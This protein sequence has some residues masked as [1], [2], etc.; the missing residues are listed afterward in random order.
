MLG[1]PQDVDRYLVGAN[2]RLAATPAAVRATTIVRSYGERT[3]IGYWA[4]L[5]GVT[6]YT[7]GLFNPTSWEAGYNATQLDHNKMGF[8][9]WRAIIPRST[10][11]T[12]MDVSKCYAYAFVFWRTTNYE[13]HEHLF[14]YF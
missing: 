9:Q 13:L 2:K 12:I 14:L 4:E 10:Y 11:I 7:Q 5:L 8:G 3:S 6:G 1:D